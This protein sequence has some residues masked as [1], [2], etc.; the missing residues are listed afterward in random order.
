MAVAAQV[1]AAVIA[2]VS[3]ILEGIMLA[4]SHVILGI[5][6]LFTFVGQSFLGFGGISGIGSAFE[7]FISGLGVSSLVNPGAQTFIQIGVGYGISAGLDMMGVDPTI[8]GMVSSIVT[9]GVHGYFAEDLIG[10]VFQSA[11]QA[12]ACRG[13]ELLG[14]YLDFDP[15]ITNLLSM[16]TF[17]LVGGIFDPDSFAEVVN[18]VAKSVIGE[19]AGYG[20]TYAGD[21]L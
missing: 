6:Q 20:I 15:I 13:V 2:G 14:D 7:G 1:I 17:K 5:S 18:T 19:L 10:G 21:A 11:L 8:S 16:S 4:M 12:A 9:G 3:V